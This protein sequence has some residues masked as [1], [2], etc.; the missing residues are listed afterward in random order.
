M[1]KEVTQMTK[2]QLPEPILSKELATLEKT[3]NSATLF[4]CERYIPIFR[5][6]ACFPW[7]WSPHR[8]F[9]YTLILFAKQRN[10][11]FKGRV[12]GKAGFPGDSVVKNPPS[13]AGEAGLLPGF[14]RSPGG[15]NGNPLQYSCLGNAIDRGAWQATIQGFVKESDIIYWLNN[16]SRV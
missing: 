12:Y 8:R 9:F 16:C 11:T 15:G 3:F 6:V 10:F 1:Q 2:G 7:H 13:S 4:V 14:G 5:T